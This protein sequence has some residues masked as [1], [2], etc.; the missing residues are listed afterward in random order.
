MKGL[1]KPISPASLATTCLGTVP[2]VMLTAISGSPAGLT[3][4]STALDILCPQ[5]RYV[6]M[7]YKP[8]VYHL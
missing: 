3:T 5:P 7:K 1:S 6:K 4:C 8:I 2:S